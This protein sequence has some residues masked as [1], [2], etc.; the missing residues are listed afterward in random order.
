MRRHYW[1]AA[2]FAFGATMCFLTVV[3]LVFSG[4]NLDWLWSLNP[5]A[6]VAFRSLGNWSIVLMSFVGSGCALAAIGLCRGTVWG[7]RLGMAI[8][9]INLIGDLV[10][11]VTR[12]DYRSLIGLPIAGAM[13]FYLACS[14]GRRKTRQERRQ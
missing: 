6:R 13:I 7:I 11:A 4:T 5:E 1:F 14:A 2:F 3:L 10:N 12:R 9:L 8:L